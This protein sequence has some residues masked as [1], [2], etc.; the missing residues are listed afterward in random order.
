MEHEFGHEVD[1]FLKVRTNNEFKTI[2][3]R[4]HAKGIKNLTDR[5]SEYG[6]TAGSK[7]QNR[8]AEMIAEAWAEFTHS[9]T[10]REL[11]REIGELILKLNKEKL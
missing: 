5:L 1:K 10:P 4:E 2:Y 6:A 11:S 7:P 8:P 3:E 9:K